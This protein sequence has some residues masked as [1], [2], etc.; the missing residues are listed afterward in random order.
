MKKGD[1][2]RQKIIVKSAE[3]FNTRGYAASSLADIMKVTGLQKGGIYNH[4]KNK[5]EIASASFDHAYHLVLN[6]FKDKLA[7]DKTS[8]DKIN[9]I[10]DVF[11]SYGENPVIK[12]GCPIFNTAMDATDV[13]PKLKKKAQEAINTLLKYVEI[14][15]EEGK[16][17]GEFK[18]EV[19]AAD[20]ALMLVSCMEG[21]LMV[22]RV[23]QSSKHVKMA[24]NLLKDYVR[25]NLMKR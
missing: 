21:A 1:S 10:I 4:F 13:H 19:N 23:N 17:E 12:G 25:N 6:R 9:S 8:T 18:P 5:D 15:I 22:S 7:L 16:I 2:T 24:G 3:L 20:F 14:K 11:V